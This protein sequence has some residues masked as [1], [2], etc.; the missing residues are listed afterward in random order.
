[1]RLL[2]SSAGLWESVC[3]R[4]RSKNNLVISNWR[5]TSFLQI[6]FCLSILQLHIIALCEATVEVLW[7]LLLSFEGVHGPFLSF[8][9]Q[10]V[11]FRRR[12]D[13]NLVTVLLLQLE[14]NKFPSVRVLFV[15]SPV[16]DYCWSSAGLLLL[17][18]GVH[19]SF[20]PFLWES[21]CFRRRS[22]I[23]LIIILLLQLETG[24]NP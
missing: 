3:F 24:I 21:V 9:W 19:M 1:M 10:S 22:N 8:L 2:L 18:E 14:T 23:N 13:N 17:F 11:C 7:G 20:L 4:H 15:D 6:G 16:A 12:S 5:R